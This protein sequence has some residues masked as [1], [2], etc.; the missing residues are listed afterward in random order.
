MLDSDEHLG[1]RCFGGDV[2]HRDLATRGSRLERLL[3][4]VEHVLAAA[5]GRT[6]RLEQAR[7]LG[8]AGEPAGQRQAVGLRAAAGEDDLAGRAPRD[9]ADDWSDVV[10]ALHAR[11]GQSFMALPSW[12]KKAD[13]STIVPR[14]Q[15]P[16]TSF[17]HSA[18]A[19]ENG[20]A[21][22]FGRSQSERVTNIIE[23]AAHPDAREGLRESAAQMGLL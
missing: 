10:G 12:H 7:H 2:T 5:R 13:V 18:V 3:H 21:S 16:V 20:I 19:T 11:G 6:H 23:R 17:E 8:P 22:V 4:R 14:I 1:V 9:I 15:E